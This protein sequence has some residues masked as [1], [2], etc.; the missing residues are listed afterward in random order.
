MRATGPGKAFVFASL[1]VAITACAPAAPSPTAAPAATPAAAEKSAEQPAAKPAEKAAEKPAAAS[2][3]WDKVLA[4]AKQ[5]GKVVIFGPAIAN[6]R[7]A[8]EEGFQQKYGIR[9]EYTGGATSELDSRITTERSAG[10]YTNDF[11]IHGLTSYIDI[12][13]PKEYLDPMPP[14]MMLPEV[15]DPKNWQGGG[16]R[17]IDPGNRVLRTFIYVN[18]AGIANPNI[19]NLNQDLQEWKD[20]LDPK[21]KGKF[22][23]DDASIAG[24]GRGTAIHLLVTKG[25]EFVRDLYVKQE[26]ALIRDRRQ[27][28]ELVP[29]GTNPVALSVDSAE[30]EKLR[31][32]GLPIAVIR[33]KDDPGYT[34]AGSWNIARFKNAPNP[35]A[36]TVFMN[37]WASKEGQE[38]VGTA[39]GF[40]SLRTDVTN[41]W[42]PEFMRP[43]AGVT[44]IDQYEWK[45][46]TEVRKPAGDKVAEI[47]K[48]RVGG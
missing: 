47:M 19:V 39:L 30:A 38:K 37:W 40:Y 14:Y 20:L 26:P 6:V 11:L 7:E 44:Y 29:R 3:E 13:I 9:V 23:T 16:I 43:V 2:A 45:F 31:L 24:A 42:V 15:T 8:I 27:L 32:Q 22:A 1:M 28:I 12:H 41:E 46:A 10:Q 33:L 35:N 36:S 18:P 25:E 5:E 48:A 34:T 21:W 4:A 17:Y